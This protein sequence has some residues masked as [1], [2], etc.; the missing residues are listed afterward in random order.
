M[1]VAEEVITLELSW[2]SVS[3]LKL[4]PYG[5]IYPS[6][7]GL[8]WASSVQ[9]HSSEYG[10]RLEVVDVERVR[11][12][13]GALEALAPLEQGDRR[14]VLEGAVARIRGTLVGTHSGLA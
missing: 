12:L 14:K 6:A 7:F 1:D 8:K 11:L 9:E 3:L 5:S 4:A 2:P 13:Q 10:A